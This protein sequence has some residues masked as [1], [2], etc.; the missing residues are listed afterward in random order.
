M[1]IHTDPDIAQLIQQELTRQRVGLSLIASE[2]Y[3]SLAV[4]EATGSVLTNKYSEGA[5]GKRYYGGNAVIDRIENLAIERAK[6]LF[7]A[8]HA[9]V[10][11]HSGSSANMAAY[12]ALLKPKDTIMAMDLSAGGHLTHGAKINF[13]GKLYTIVPY[14]VS[15]NNE[16]LDF[17]EI[18][19]LALQHKPKLIVAGASSY[20]RT[21]DFSAF[22]AIADDVGAF[23]LADIAHLAGLVAAQLHPSPIPHADV[24]T[25]TTQKTLRGPRGGVILA[26][27]AFGPAIDKAVM[28]GIQGGALDHITAAKAVCF[29]DASEQPFRHYQQR[30]LNNAH[31][32]AKVFAEHEIRVVSGGTGNHMFL[33]DLT[34]LGISGKTAEEALERCGIFSN[35]NMIP[36]DTRKPLDPSGLRFGTP[37]ITTRGLNT[38]D[39]RMLGEAIV[40]VL[41]HP[42][43]EATRTSATNLVKQLTDQYPLYPELA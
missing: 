22:R 36:F 40:A 38:D 12:M 1:L 9:N 31:A 28:P 11:P 23:L 29:K 33:I 34:N 41:R 35:R 15:K 32:L 24:V 43:D 26:K 37:S 2:N 8:D 7:G 5:P 6:K 27:E 3:A 21:I 14:G 39:V 10:E 42:S 25:I 20:S 13:S 4:L 19:S 30:V 18:R 16:M 17:D